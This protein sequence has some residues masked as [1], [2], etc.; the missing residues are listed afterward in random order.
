MLWLKAWLE[1]RWRVVW[2]LV[3]GALVFG[4]FLVSGAH[5]AAHAPATHPMNLPETVSTALLGL[6]GV[7]SFFAAIMLAGSGVETTT[8]RPGGSEKGGAGSTLFTLS[9]P[10]TRARLFA[11]RTV[12]GILETLV[13]LTLFAVVEGLLF[14]S[15]GVNAHDA[16]GAFAEI[17]A[18]NF[19]VYAISACLATFCDEG[20]RFRVSAIVLAVLVTFVSLTAS[21]DRL[22]RSLAAASPFITHQVPW[23]LIVSACVLAAL[24]LAAALAI[25]QRRDY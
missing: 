7:V 4:A 5:A 17:V 22:P 18:C 13:L 2:A 16:L 24:F 12:T 25:V 1:T 8:T 14:S 3:M 20:W 11:V 10:V 15:L 6:T 21:T 19:T 23:V 9:L